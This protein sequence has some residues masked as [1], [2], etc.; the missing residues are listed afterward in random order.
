MANFKRLC[1]WSLGIL[2]ALWS[3]GCSAL[4]PS[5]PWRSLYE[6]KL[7]Q[8]IAELNEAA[9]NSN[10]QDA[11]G[12]LTRLTWARLKDGTTALLGLPA[13][14]NP[15]DTVVSR[16]AV[17]RENEWKQ[18]CSQATGQDF[19]AWMWMTGKE[20]V[21]NTLDVY[22]ASL[23]SQSTQSVQLPDPSLPYCQFAFLPEGWEIRAVQIKAT[24]KP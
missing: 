17:L 12:N 15:V 19:Q 10:F 1:V 8:P 6:K 7:G 20:A 16:T 13:Y 14:G 22:V 5:P 21:G 2:L 18:A 3:V 11:K 9:L 24:I 4:N 23:K